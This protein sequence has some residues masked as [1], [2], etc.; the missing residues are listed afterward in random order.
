MV[1]NLLLLERCCGKVLKLNVFI[2]MSILCMPV[3]ILHSI[4]CLV[5]GA[6]N[7]SCHVDP[8]DIMYVE[9]FTSP[10]SPPAS[11]EFLEL[12]EVV[13]HGGAW[14]PH[15]PQCGGG[16]HICIINRCFGRCLSHCMFKLHGHEL[17][18][19][20]CLKNDQMRTFYKYTQFL[21]SCYCNNVS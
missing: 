12:V 10:P 11:L 20:F 15:A 5:T 2:G 14:S 4:W 19:N 9:Q 6:V 18:E 3:S 1:L 17:I 7:H 16:S 8:T 13:M 21:K